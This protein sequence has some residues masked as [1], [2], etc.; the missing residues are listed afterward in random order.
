MSMAKDLWYVPKKGD[1]R[2]KKVRLIELSN[3]KPYPDYRLP[4][5]DSKDRANLKRSIQEKGIHDPLQVVPDGDGTF[6]ALTGMTRLEIAKELKIERVPCIERDV[7]KDQ[8]KAFVIA[9]NLARRQL[10]ARQRDVLLV[11]LWG[12]KPTERRRDDKGKFKEDTLVA[13]CN[14]DKPP[15]EQLSKARKAVQEA[16]KICSDAGMEDAFDEDKLSGRD[17]LAKAELIKA[18]YNPEDA[19]SCGRF[20]KAD[21]VADAEIPDDPG[22]V[23]RMA[24]ERALKGKKSPG[25]KKGQRKREKKEDKREPHEDREESV[26][27]AAGQGPGHTGEQNGSTMTFEEIGKLLGEPSLPGMQ[28]VNHKWYDDLTRHIE[29]R[30]M[31]PLFK[32]IG[33]TVAKATAFEVL[34]D[35]AAKAVSGKYLPQTDRL[36]AGQASEIT[37]R[38][39]AN[40]DG[41]GDKYRLQK[42]E[43]KGKSQKPVEFVKELG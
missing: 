39:I 38:K 24:L 10:A 29:T 25:I 30:C 31:V 19:A 7:P 3:L 22:E 12:E 17:A 40:K 33:P 23:K 36:K 5:H 6:T 41:K 16:R 20:L 35:I 42:G 14:L 21:G 37:S 11:E 34:K 9:D 2:L 43:S 27:E 4:D 15:K 32:S 13:I 1:K 8:R 28:M 26:E 18:G